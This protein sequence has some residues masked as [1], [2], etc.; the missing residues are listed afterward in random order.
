LATSGRA[1]VTCENGEHVVS[2]SGSVFPESD[3]DFMGLVLERETVGIC[4]T[5]EF[6]PA[7]PLP[8]DPQPNPEYGYPTYMA[9]VTLTPPLQGVTYRYTP[10]GVREDGSRVRF[11]S[12][13]ASDHR[14]YALTSCSSAP[15][16]RGELEMI[17]FNGGDLLFGIDPCEPDCWTESIYIYM[18]VTALESIVGDGWNDLLGQ[19][20]DVFGDRSFCSMIGGP[21]HDISSIVPAPAGACGAVPVE[22]MSWGGLKASY[23]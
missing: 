11:F 5:S 7:I 16:L 6:V 1:Q 4:T 17:D 3:D 14:S 2:I 18:D 19:V 13:C 15:F 22:R 10:Y 12:A 23:R 9:T 20:V 8:F 21:S